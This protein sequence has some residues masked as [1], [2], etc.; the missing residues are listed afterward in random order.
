MAIAPDD[1]AKYLMKLREGKSFEDVRREMLIRGYSQD[2]VDENMILLNELLIL[3]DIHQE[4]Q[5]DASQLIVA[6]VVLMIVSVILSIY[7]LVASTSIVIWL[8]IAAFTSGLL[9][10]IYGN[11]QRQIRF[12]PFARRFEKGT[13]NSRRRT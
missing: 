11:R 10:I 1:I 8:P 2:D 6:G 7:G 5:K 12:M 13:L 4:K 3:S 9:M